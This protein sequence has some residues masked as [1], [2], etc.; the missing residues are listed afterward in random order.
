MTVEQETPATSA[1]LA[2]NVHPMS[3]ELT[4]QPN[5]T[6]LQEDSQE[7][8]SDFPQQKDLGSVVEFILLWEKEK[9][10]E[11]AERLHMIRECRRASN[12]G[13]MPKIK[14]Y[15]APR[16]VCEDFKELKDALISLFSCHHHQP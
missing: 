16:G 3:V 1:D 5:A 11:M 13:Q 4:T 14:R 2:K 15:P 6:G 7:N 12:L 9:K 10:Q 8:R